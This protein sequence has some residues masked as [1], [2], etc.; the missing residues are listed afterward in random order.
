[1][2]H[3]DDE[4]ELRTKHLPLFAWQHRE[5]AWSVPVESD[6]WATEAWELGITGEFV[7]AGSIEGDEET[8]L[9]NE[10]I[11]R[12][13]RILYLSD[14]WDGEG[15]AGYLQDT[16]ERAVGLLR[17]Y[18]K[19]AH[20]ELEMNLGVPRIAPADDGSIDLH[21]KTTDRQLLINI[22]ADGSQAPTFYGDAR[23]GD[24]ISGSIQSEI[25]HVLMVSWLVA[26]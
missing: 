3:F 18:A 6:A 4:A 26:R 12:S 5:K 15:S 25:M 9:L 22:P 7:A 23:E 14:D 16:W 8:S 17:R 21:W 11:E 1:M 2:R 20:T 24:N 10:A 13:R 19:S